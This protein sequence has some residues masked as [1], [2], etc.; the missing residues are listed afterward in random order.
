MHDR[1]RSLG[2]S[3][4]LKLGSLH[5]VAKAAL[6]IAYVALSAVLLVIWKTRE[7]SQPVP[8][9]IGSNL[10]SMDYEPTDTFVRPVYVN[11]KGGDMA[12]DGASTMLGVL[13]LPAH[14]YPGL[15]ARVKWRRCRRNLDYVPGEPKDKGC[16]WVEKDVPVQPYTYV[17]ETWVHIFENDEVLVIPS[18]LFPSDENY[19]GAPY[20]YK[21]F[22]DKRGIGEDE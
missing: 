11:G 21:N 15:T 5:P 17:A 4:L 10:T 2:R 3:L 19:P 1:S 9:W 7:V 20:P 18:A 14:W 16:R 6:L 8:T 22:F 13:S 12:G